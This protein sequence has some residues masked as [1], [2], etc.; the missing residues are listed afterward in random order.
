MTRPP[1]AMS[2][3]EHVCVAPRAQCAAPS[4]P[5]TTPQAERKRSAHGQG[6]GEC[7]E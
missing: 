3:P 4:R 6:G 2:S 1:R 7:G 5:E